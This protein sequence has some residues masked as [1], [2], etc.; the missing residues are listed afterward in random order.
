M[1]L[2]SS[3][4]VSLLFNGSRI[5]FCGVLL[6]TVIAFFISSR[7]P[8]LKLVTV[9]A[10]VAIACGLVIVRDRAVEI[11][12]KSA[13]SNR[14]VAAGL[15]AYEGDLNAEG[16]GTL[17]FRREVDQVGLDQISHSTFSELMFGR[18]TSN[19]SLITG[20]LFRGY[21]GMVDPNRM[22]HDEWVRV[23]YEWGLAGLFF[24]C[25]FWVSVVAYAIQGVRTDKQGFAK[26]LMV[27]VPAL[28]VAL[29]GEN[30]IAG[31]GNA[32]SIGFLMLFGFATLAHRYPAQTKRSQQIRFE[33][34]PELAN[35][36][37]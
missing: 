5:W 28:L 23:L 17:R 14:I 37:T 30:F 18:G 26:P 33:P 24:W 8:W 10:L 12:Q 20:S 15:A 13:S 35:A 16:L 22:V 4:G 19:G 32:M 1:L 29:A 6:A 11:I 34:S 2:C 27:Y 3:L 36:G 21:A 25:V 7:P 9:G 31:A